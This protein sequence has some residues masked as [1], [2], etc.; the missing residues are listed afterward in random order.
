MDELGLI[1][2]GPRPADSARREVHPHRGLPYWYCEDSVSRHAFIV[3]KILPSNRV[4]LIAGI[5][6]AGKSRFAIPAFIMWDA[7]LPVLG[8]KSTPV[9]WCVVCGDRPE[10]DTQDMLQTIGFRPSDVDII[11]AFGKRQRPMYEVMSEIEKR[12]AQ[13]VFW[14]GFDLLVRNPNNPH[15]VKEM[16]SSIT[17]YCEDGLTVLG[18]VGVAKL[19]P[20]ETYQNPRQLVAGS[21]IWERATSTN[22]VIVPTHPNDIENGERL[23]YVCLKNSPSFA[24][25]GD[26]DGSGILAFRDWECRLQGDA[27]K[28]MQTRM[29]STSTKN[30]HGHP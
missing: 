14:E 12:N 3:E 17:A 24:V 7:G 26:F 23:M 16:L 5:S 18:T 15:E 22:L 20:H 27:L 9:R 11:P 2:P 29:R 1:H 28:A 25:V 13:F 21:S 19:K 10:S 8:L 6:S 4:H 30:G